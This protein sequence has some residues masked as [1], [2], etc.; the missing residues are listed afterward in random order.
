MCMFNL[1][2]IY[3]LDIGIP[4]DIGF[5]NC[6]SQNKLLKISEKEIVHFLVQI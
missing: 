4:Y 2:D 5:K 6:F 1:F 3:S